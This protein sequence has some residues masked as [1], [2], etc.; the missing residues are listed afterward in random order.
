MEKQYIKYSPEFRKMVV[1]LLES[2]ETKSISEARRKF[3]IGGTCTIHK[4]IKRYNKQN[5]LPELKI[6]NLDD[7]IEQLRLSDDKLY[8]KIRQSFNQ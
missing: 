8:D 2:G 6:R 5:L 4:W 1:D 7:A 3:N